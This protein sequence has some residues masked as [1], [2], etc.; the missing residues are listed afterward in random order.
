[1]LQMLSALQINNPKKHNFL[2][3]NV[4]MGCI[5]FFLNFI[6]SISKENTTITTANNKRII[7]NNSGI[8]DVNPEIIKIFL[9]QFLK[10]DI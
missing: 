4:I 8:N 10:K 1:M 3:L 9:E 5:T 6:K 2:I 7:Q